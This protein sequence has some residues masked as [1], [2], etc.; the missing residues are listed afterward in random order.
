MNTKAVVII[1]ILLFAMLTSVVYAFVQ[2]TIAR[3]AQREALVQKMAA[4]VARNEAEKLRFESEAQRAIAVKTMEQF[5]TA[6]LELDALKKRC[7]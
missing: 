2:Q 6:L 4:E 7:K 5:Q 3:E 1:S